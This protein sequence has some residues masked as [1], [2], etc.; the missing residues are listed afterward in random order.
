MIRKKKKTKKAEILP[1]TWRME[2][3]KSICSPEIIPS[4]GQK[5]HSVALQGL[6]GRS[7]SSSKKQQIELKVKLIVF[8]W[9]FLSV[10]LLGSHVVTIIFFVSSVEKKCLRPASVFSSDSSSES[11]TNSTLISYLHHFVVF[12]NWLRLPRSLFT[13]RF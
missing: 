1:E 4:A 7:G 10:V 13:I 6:M 2:G 8:S 5:C 9:L 11:A 12:L 3:L